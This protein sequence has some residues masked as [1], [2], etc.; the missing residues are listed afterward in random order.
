MADRGAFSAFCE[1]LALAI[2][3]WRTPLAALVAV[4]LAIPLGALA[5]SG[6]DLPGVPRYDYVALTGDATGFYAAAREFLASWGRLGVPVVAALAAATVAAAALLVRAWRTRSV[7]RHWLVALGALGFALVASAAVAK[8]HS[9]GAAVF[10]WPL[11]WSLP[12]L[13]YRALGGPLDPGIAFGFGLVLSLLANAVT[14]VATAYVG[15]YATG[16]RS[17]GLGAATLYSFWPLLVGLI[18]GSRAWENGTW[19]VEAGL[20]LYTEPL[21]TALVATAA[22]LLLS[23][24]LTELR[25]A[26]SG[27]LLG[28]AT[29]VKLSNGLLAAVLFV[30]V[31]HRLGTRGALPYLAGLLAFAPLVAIYGPKGYSAQFDSPGERHPFSADYVVRSWTDSLLFSPRTLLVLVP[32]SIVGAIA[33]R[34]WWPR[35]VLVVWALVNPIFYSFHRATPEHPRYLFASLPAV[36]VL[37]VAGLAAAAAVVHV[38]R[39]RKLKPM[40]P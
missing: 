34:A 24:R 36:F 31:A 40:P 2:V 27:V 35:A 15:L 38:V 16:R 11:V 39:R 10:G 37:W 26:T 1:A 3:T 7:G 18:G 6:H 21:S 33:L 30:L 14:V 4:R 12:M 25:L 8:M 23:P 9:P 5:A 29:A 17:I 22:A 28:L 20:S 13:P 32:F 19:T